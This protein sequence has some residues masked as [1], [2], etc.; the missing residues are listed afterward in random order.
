M[1]VLNLV[2]VEWMVLA[3]SVLK[4]KYSTMKQIGKNRGERKIGSSKAQKVSLVSV[5][6][7]LK[8][9]LYSREC[10]KKSNAGAILMKRFK[11][12]GSNQYEERASWI[13]EN[14]TEYYNEEIDKFETKLYGQSVCNGC[15]AVGLGY[16]KRCI[17]ELKSD[18]RSTS[19]ISEVFNVPCRGRSSVVHGNRVRVPRT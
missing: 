18:I 11:A 4:R 17:E 13:L 15:Y 12:W 1:R 16:S 19:I 9:S 5:E 14:L 6:H 10:L 2:Y 7:D 8:F 3:P